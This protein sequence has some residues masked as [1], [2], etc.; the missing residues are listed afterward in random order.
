[1]PEL[2]VARA[3]NALSA[4]AVTRCGSAPRCSTSLAARQDNMKSLLICSSLALA[5]ACSLSA[6]ADTQ[7]S[8]AEA[9][10]IQATLQAWGCSGGKLEKENEATGIYEVDDAK[11]RDGQY[12]MKLDTDFKVIV[13]TRD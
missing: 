6:L 11:C 3:L 7:V 2:A 9:E 10:K 13:I 8:P 4:A 1:V 5:T 12:D